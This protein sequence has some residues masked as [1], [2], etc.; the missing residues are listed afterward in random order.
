[1]PNQ[2]FGFNLEFILIKY[3]KNRSI[4]QKSQNWKHVFMVLPFLDNLHASK[5]E[6]FF[7]F[8]KIAEQVKDVLGD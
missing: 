6:E 1:M 3:K 7:F 8:L 5:N 4:F 2:F